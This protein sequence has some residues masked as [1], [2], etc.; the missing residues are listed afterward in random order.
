MAYLYALTRKNR[1]YNIPLKPDDISDY[2]LMRITRFPRAA[3]DELC[4][5]LHEDLHRATDRSHAIPVECQVMTALQF[6]A[7]GSFQWM[8]GRSSCL[9]QTSTSRIIDDVARALCKL[10][11]NY[12]KFSTDQ[13]TLM[14]S[15][16]AFHSIA[17][18]P[19]VIGAIDC[20]HIAI[21]S[22]SQHEDAYVNRKGV[23]TVNIQA[24]CDHNMQ[25][26]NIVARWPGSTHDSFIWRDSA[27]HRQFKHGQI[28]GGWL[29]GMY[30]ALL[31]FLD[32]KLQLD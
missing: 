28:Q 29:I 23:H 32:Y 5:L 14:S 19:N 15:K 16:I 26:L 25:L 30:N 12:I 22:P 31:T 11:P 4:D 3:V 6:F 27:L 8:V 7:S 21:K 13:N 18:F 9:S 24:V 10:A 17:G 2:E 20:T 1:V